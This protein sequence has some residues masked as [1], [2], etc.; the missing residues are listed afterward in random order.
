[1]IFVINSTRKKSTIEKCFTNIINHYRVDS[2]VVEIDVEFEDLGDFDGLM[3]E[4]D[5]NH[6]LI[7]VNKNKMHDFNT[8]ISHELIH[9][10]QILRDGDTN[11]PEAYNNESYFASLL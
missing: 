10:M 1:M 9:V 3:H 4:E 5:D 6:F 7:S 8:I 2:D 11:E